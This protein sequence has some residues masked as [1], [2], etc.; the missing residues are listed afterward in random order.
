MIPKASLKRILKENGAERVS[1]EALDVYQEEV[2]N[3]AAEIAATSAKLAAH[4]S[5]KTVKADD[6]TLAV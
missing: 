3:Y 2:V 4:A 1:A 5:R 6:I